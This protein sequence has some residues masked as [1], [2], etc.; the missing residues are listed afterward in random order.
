MGLLEADRDRIDRPERGA[1]TCRG[2]ASTPASVVS[3]KAAW[4]PANLARSGPSASRGYFAIDTSATLLRALSAMT[5]FPS[6][7]A[8]IFRTTPPAGGNHPGL[9][10]LGLGIET[11]QGIWFNRR[12]AV[13]DHS[14]QECDAVW[15]RCRPARRG[16]VLH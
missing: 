9:K 13:P 7:V 15:L 8:I 10:F 14:V 1:P 16:P 6:R 3:G 4:P 5:R 11:D 2:P 12:F